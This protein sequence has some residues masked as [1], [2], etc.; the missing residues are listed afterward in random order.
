MK[1]R[2]SG[3]SARVWL[4]A[5]AVALA[6]S[7]VW[8]AAFGASRSGSSRGRGL[9]AQLVALGLIELLFAGYSVD[10]DSASM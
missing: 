2:S 5:L 8:T 4:H 6:G 9:M 10:G 1:R 7:E 3:H